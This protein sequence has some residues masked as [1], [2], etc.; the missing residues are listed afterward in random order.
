MDHATAAT[1]AAAIA[2]RPRFLA[3]TLAAWRGFG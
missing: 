1:Q 2:R 3:G